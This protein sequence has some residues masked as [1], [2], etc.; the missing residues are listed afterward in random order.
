MR[1]TLILLTAAAVLLVAAPAASACD[2]RRTSGPVKH[3][4]R[5]ERAPLILGDSTMILA[6]PLLGRRGLE[7]DAQG[8][9]QF[10]A[11]VAMLAQRKRAGRLPRVAILALGA[12]GAIGRG[13]M[14][15]AVRVMGRDRILG[16]VTPRQAASSDATMRWEIGRASCRERV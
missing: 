7:A 10:A 15:R 8:C 14:A 1:R 9:R 11:G 2:A 12:N 16:L 3:K 4:P 13:S 6:A 5:T